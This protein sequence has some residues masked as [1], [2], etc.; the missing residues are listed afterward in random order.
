MLT[1]TCCLETLLYHGSEADQA[2]PCKKQR[3]AMGC[4]N[5]PN[6]GKLNKHSDDAWLQV[7]TRHH[8]LRPPQAVVGDQD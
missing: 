8:R 2:G 4:P 3:G 5:L 6:L 1:H 7:A